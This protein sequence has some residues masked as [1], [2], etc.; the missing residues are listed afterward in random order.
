MEDMPQS[1]IVEKLR[2][3]DLRQMAKERN[4]PNIWKM[5]RDQLVDLLY[6]DSKEDNQNNHDT[7]EH[8]APEKGKGEYIRV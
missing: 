4:I 3:Q 2:I 7:E 6:P 1:L 5:R 8:D